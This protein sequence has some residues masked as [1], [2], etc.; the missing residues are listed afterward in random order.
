[1]T[2]GARGEKEVSEGKEGLEE[3]KGWWRGGKK[4]CLPTFMVSS[5]TI[6]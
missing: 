6:I 2:E 1:M 5:V 4:I 3:G